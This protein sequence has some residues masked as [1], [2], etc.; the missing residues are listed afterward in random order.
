MTVPQLIDHREA[1]KIAGIAGMITSPHDGEAL[2]ACRILTKALDRHGLRVG[3][4]VERGLRPLPVSSSHNWHGPAPVTPLRPHQR[5]VAECLAWGAFVT[6]W[7]MTFLR[8]IADERVLTDRQMDKLNA[9]VR[10]V[11][12]LR[13]GNGE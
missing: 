7:E 13:A 6:N 3:D 2:S 1:R 11:R 5:L 12:Q 10:K 4:V 9:I 8:S